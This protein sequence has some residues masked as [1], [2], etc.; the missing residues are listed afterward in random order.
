MRGYSRWEA[1]TGGRRAA[2]SASRPLQRRPQSRRRGQRAR[3]SIGFPSRKPP[4]TTWR[5]TGKRALRR[6]CVVAENLTQI[7]RTVGA[8]ISVAEGLDVVAEAV[9]QRHE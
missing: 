4:F 6:M 1:T 8:E 2:A 5:T 7:K 3:Y 9:G